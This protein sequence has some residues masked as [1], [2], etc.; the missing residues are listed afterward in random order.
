MDIIE[1]MG[2]RLYFLI[3]TLALGA[4]FLNACDTKFKPV[5]RK[6]LE[7]PSVKDPIT[8]FCGPDC[9]SCGFSVD[10]C[11]SLVKSNLG[12]LCG[13][14][15]KKNCYTLWMQYSKTCHAICSSPDKNLADEKKIATMSLHE[16]GHP[17]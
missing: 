13:R 9:S 16:D 7:N 11:L 3:V 6:S 17:R 15:E 14:G 2:N 5:P 4:F 12:R 1:K 10:K 8:I